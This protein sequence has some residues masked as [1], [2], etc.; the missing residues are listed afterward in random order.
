MRAQARRV[1]T[2]NAIE[3]AFREVRRRTRP[4]SCLNNPASCE[5]V[6]YGVFSHLNQTWGDK[7]LREFTH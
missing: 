1:R 6:I 5:R 2:T 7:P 4:M 3:R